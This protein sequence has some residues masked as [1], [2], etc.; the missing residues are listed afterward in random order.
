M[1]PCRLVPQMASITPHPML[2]VLLSGMAHVRLPD[3]TGEAWVMEG[4]NGLLVAVDDAGEGHYTDY[5]SDKTAVALQ[6][7][8]ENGIIPSH[9]VAHSGAC[10]SPG[11][12]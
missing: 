2:F 3:G 7:P 1:L 8:F 11:L 6:I 9:T 4:V 10:K 5:P 12:G